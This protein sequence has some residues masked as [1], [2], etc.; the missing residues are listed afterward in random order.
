MMDSGNISFRDLG[1][2]SKYAKNLFVRRRSTCAVMPEDPFLDK[3]ITNTDTGFERLSDKESFRWY[4]FFTGSDNQAF[5]YMYRNNNFSSGYSLLANIWPFEKTARWKA[6]FHLQNKASDISLIL[7]R[8]PGI[9][10]LRMADDPWFS[11]HTTQERFE[12]NLTALGLP[13]I[14][15]FGEPYYAD[16]S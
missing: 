1:I 7:L 16:D 11:A 5:P 14:N 8:Y 4:S 10:F 12:I 3:V 2:N 13:A 6:P 15:F 9:S